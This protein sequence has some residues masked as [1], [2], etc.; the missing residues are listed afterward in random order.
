MAKI[1]G[2]A[3]I[4]GTRYRFQ[5]KSVHV[6]NFWQYVPDFNALALNP[7]KNSHVYE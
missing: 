4:Q 2:H 6:P 1:K 3:E 7:E 5:N